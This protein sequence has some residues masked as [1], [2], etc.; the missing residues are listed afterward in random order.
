MNMFV[1]CVSL[2]Q[3][4]KNIFPHSGYKGYPV[5]LFHT[6]TFMNWS[7]KSSYGKFHRIKMLQ[8]IKQFD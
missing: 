8:K 3:Y 1:Q 4:I 2:V 6:F 5:V 7:S